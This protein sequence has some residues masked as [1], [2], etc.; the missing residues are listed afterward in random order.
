M[1]YS[2]G[3]DGNDPDDSGS[4]G[5]DS[6]TDSNGGGDSPT[7]SN[8]DGTPPTASNGA[9]TPSPTSTSSPEPS[10][11]TDA[12]GPTSAPADDNVSAPPTAAPALPSC[13][14]L[15]VS[16]FESPLFIETNRESVRFPVLENALSE[17]MRELLPF[18]DP[19]QRRL[20]D[21]S[22]VDHSETSYYIGNVDLVEGDEGGKRKICHFSVQCT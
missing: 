18:C 2:Y 9:G 17:A 13:L 20:E 8:G 10:P 4:G 21:G 1:S 5:G 16:S 6:P 7:D 12:V 11:T 19:G 3:Y 15:P 22:E 14:G